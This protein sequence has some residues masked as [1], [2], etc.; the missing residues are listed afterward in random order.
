MDLSQ[1]TGFCPNGRALN[2]LSIYRRSTIWICMLLKD[3]IKSPLSICL[4]AHLNFNG[5]SEN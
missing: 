2:F 1:R 3:A 5:F 4:S